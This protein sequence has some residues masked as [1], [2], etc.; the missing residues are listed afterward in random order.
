MA[1]CRKSDA[2]YA[3]RARGLSELDALVDENRTDSETYGAIG[4]VHAEMMSSA[5]SEGN[6]MKAKG[7]LQRAAA[8]FCDGFRLDPMNT[9]TGINA[10][11]MLL[12]LGEKEKVKNFGPIVLF[13]AERAVQDKWTVA[14]VLELALLI[15]DEDRARATAE[16]FM[17]MLEGGWEAEVTAMSLL[18]THSAA[19]NSL[20]RLLVPSD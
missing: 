13:A 9:Y 20:M 19:R 1:L 17:S 11:R 7:H 5:E 18:K 10:I 6:S 14:T 4:R 12:K 3:E 8:A 16:R 15:G 2:S